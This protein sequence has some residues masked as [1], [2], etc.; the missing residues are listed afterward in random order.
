[1]VQLLVRQFYPQ[2][3]GVVEIYHKHMNMSST[4]KIKIPF[5]SLKLPRLWR[6]DTHNLLKGPH[7]ILSKWSH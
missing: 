4:G 7:N 3:Y 5:L 1:M 6:G 2:N